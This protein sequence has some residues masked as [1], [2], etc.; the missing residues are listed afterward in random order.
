MHG[1]LRAQLRR[2]AGLA[3]AGVDVCVD[4]AGPNGVHAHAFG[5]DL[6]RQTQGEGVYGRLG[7]GVVH[8]L[9]RRTQPRRG[10]RQV[11]D[12]AARAA[13]PGAEAAHRLARAP[14]R[15]EDVDGEHALDAG[16]A[17]LVH[18]RRHVHHAGVVDQTAERRDVGA[19]QPVELHEHRHRLG[20]IGHVG[21][22]QHGAPA[23]RTHVSGHGLGGGVLAVVDGH[24]PAARRGQP[25]RGCADAAAGAGDEQGALEPGLMH[26]PILGRG[27]LA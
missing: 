26:S 20:L 6:A 11:D 22:Q 17:H 18:A 2:A 24:V 16:A 3:A 4:D 19:G 9:P 14:E 27:R 7:R 15:A 12:G 21:L 8:V 10:R 5:R 25:G 1:H 23:Q 13:V